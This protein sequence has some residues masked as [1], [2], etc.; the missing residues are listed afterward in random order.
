MN[1]KEDKLITEE[2]IES[3]CKKLGIH[4]EK[5]TNG[6]GGMYLKQENGSYK[7][8]TDDDFEE[9]FVFLKSNNIE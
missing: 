9:M 5:S 4:C 7:K 8:L 3:A 1:E 2:L 6:E